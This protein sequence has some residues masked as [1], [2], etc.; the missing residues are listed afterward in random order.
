MNDGASDLV[1]SEFFTYRH[2]RSNSFGLKHRIAS[3]SLSSVQVCVVFMATTGQ[4]NTLSLSLTF[5]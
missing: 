2:L 3:N 1:R 5:C 4:R